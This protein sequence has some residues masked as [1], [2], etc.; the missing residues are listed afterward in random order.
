MMTSAYS[1]PP[2]PISELTPDGPL[3]TRAIVTDTVL[4]ELRNF[5]AAY[6]KKVV[7]ADISLQIPETGSMILLGPSGTGKSTLLRTLAGISTASPSFRTWGEAYYMGEPLNDQSPERPELVGQSTQMMM[8]SVL[9]NIVVNLQERSQMTRAMQRD[10]ASRLLIHIGLPELCERLDDLAVTLPLALQRHLAI[11]RLVVARP[12]LLCIDEPTSALNDAESTRLLT[13]IRDEATRRAVLVTL[14]NQQHA[15]ILGGMG[16]LLAGG[17]IQE[18]QPIPELF[19]VPQSAVAREF[20][21]SGSCH[22]ASPDTPAEDLDESLPPPKPLPKA[23]LNYARHSAGPRGFLWLKRNQL[24]GT[25]KPG[26][27]FDQE[28]DLKALQ[29]VGVTTLLTLMENHLDE[30]SLTPF[31]IKSIW[32]PIKDMDAPT[33]EQ[34]IRICKKIDR[35]IAEN[36]VVAVHC[37]AGMGRTGTIL[38]SYLIWEGKNALD[39][40]ETAR[41]I[42]PR[43]VQS[44]VQIDFLSLFDAE[45]NKYNTNITIMEEESAT[46]LTSLD[47]INFLKWREMKSRKS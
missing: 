47:M 34:G 3:N 4:L 16:V 20:A 22:V 44:Q 9:D 38:A 31:G 45:I 35:L 36:E 23:A 12:R 18:Q 14:H 5:G 8:S 30:A 32:E 15:R 13:Y 28:Y 43:W 40:L 25:P 6:A 29:G 10:L 11:L 46:D 7:L 37:L 26:V 19:E 41:S 33:I 27:Y 42:E 21:H 1:A 24:A 2:L 39:A 17:Y